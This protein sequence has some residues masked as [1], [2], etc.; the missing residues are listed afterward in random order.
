MADGVIYDRRAARRDSATVDGSS[1][2]AVAVQNRSHP[3]QFAQYRVETV[4]G[5]IDQTSIIIGVVMTVFELSF[6]VE[7]KLDERGYSR[8]IDDR[9][10]Y[11]VWK[12]RVLPCTFS[13]YSL[14]HRVKKRLDACFE[15]KTTGL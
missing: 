8:Q 7:S 4:F 14:N 15:K 5:M 12:C 10:I 9:L 3:R 13:K 11:D 2:V 1:S 6:A